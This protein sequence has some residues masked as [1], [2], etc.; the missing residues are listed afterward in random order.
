MSPCVS[1]LQQRSWVVET[2]HY[3]VSL[4]LV[5]NSDK[6]GMSKIS[7]LCTTEVACKTKPFLYLFDGLRLHLP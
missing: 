4:A 6:V 1:P 3:K 2:A 5:W 7:G